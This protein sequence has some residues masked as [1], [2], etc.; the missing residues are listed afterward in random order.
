MGYNGSAGIGGRNDVTGELISGGGAGGAGGG[1]SGG[2][3]GGGGSGGSGGGGGGGGGG[4]PFFLGNGGE[5]GD[6]GAGGFGG[7]GGSGG[8]GGIGGIGGA[9]GGAMQIYAY[10]RITLTNAE[11]NAQGGAGSAGTSGTAGQAGTAGSAGSGGQPGSGGSLLG[12]TGGTGGSGAAGGTG[13]SGGA[14]G[15]GGTGGGGAGGTIKL[16]GSVV[17]GIGT[18]I[19]AEGGA[20]GNA[21]AL[22]RFVL[23]QNAGFFATQK[24][25]SVTFNPFTGL[26]FNYEPTINARGGAAEQVDGPMGA[27]PMIKPGVEAVATP[28]IPGLEGGAAPFGLLQLDSRT[29]LNQAVFDAATQKGAPL[30][31]VRVDGGIGGLVDDFAGYDL[32]LFANLTDSQTFDDPMLGVGAQAFQHALMLGGWM[33]DGQFVTDG[34][35]DPLAHL[36]PGEIYAMLVPEDTSFFTVTASLGSGQDKVSFLASTETL[37]DGQ[38]LFVRPPGGTATVN[39]QLAPAGEEIGG[40]TWQQLVLHQGGGTSGTVHVGSTS[41]ELEILLSD[42]SGGLVAADAVMLRKVGEVL[43]HLRTLTLDGNPL[44]NRAHDIFLPA[45]Q[46]NAVDV[47]FD[48]DLAPVVAPVANQPSTTA[49]SFDGNDMAVIYASPSLAMTGSSTVELRFQIASADRGWTN[50]IHKSDGSGYGSRAFSVWVNQ[51][52]GQMFLSTSDAIG[53]QYWYLPA[54]TVK[55]GEWYEFA[56]VID[57]TSGTVHAYLNGAEVLSATIRTNAQAYAGTSFYVGNRTGGQGFTGVIDDLAIWAEARSFAEV[58]EDFA[59]GVDDSQVA[60]HWRFDAGELATDSSE[61]HNGGYADGATPVLGP[62]RLKVT[63]APGDPIDL[64]PVFDDTQVNVT[65]DGVY[66]LVTPVSGFT[67]TAHVTLVARDG[68][69]APHDFR[70]RES[71]TGFDVTFGANAIYGNKFNDID[72]DGVRDAGEPGVEGIQ[73]FLDDNGNGALDG[74][75][76]VTWT[77]LNGDYAFRGLPLRRVAG[78]RAGGPRGLAG[79][80]AERRRRGHRLIANDCDRYRHAQRGDL[81]VQR[82]DTPGRAV[83]RRQ[84]PGIRRQQ[85]KLGTHRLIHDRSALQARQHQHLRAPCPEDRRHRFRQAHVRP[86]DRYVVRHVRAHDRGRPGRAAVLQR[87][88]VDPGRPVVSA[89]GGHRSRRGTG[90]RLSE[91]HADLVRQQRHSPARCGVRR[92]QPP[93][94]RPYPGIRVRRLCRRHRRRSDLERRAQRQRGRRGFLHGRRR[95]GH[96]ARGALGIQRGERWRRARRLR[97]QERRRA[98]RRHH[99]RVAGAHQCGEWHGRQPRRVDYAPAGSDEQQCDAG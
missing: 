81:H 4:Q 47:S 33:R 54:G 50:L 26:Q 15:A 46:S 93:A 94:H 57:R 49:A 86:V 87:R 16:V 90:E 3:G 99:G 75:E 9:G 10:G 84:R 6:G 79:R 60:G 27:N 13:G 89:C 32:L 28:Y 44:D 11:F 78:L 52:N 76:Q 2:G 43:P 1:G 91:R 23:G 74:G 14:G 73:I 19:H 63:D 37:S 95:H 18:E 30:A 35:L 41:P 92:K 17:N 34:G 56:S 24:L 71:E 59:A 96:R 22:G 38:V 31:L 77:D 69:G 8:T 85:R 20:G 97:Q 67:G 80:A 98:R 61:N 48:A 68:S 83:V 64:L 45:V 51:A 58:N 70:G 25:V 40:T 62:I 88:R 7:F 12:G 66:L 36:N 53:E 29:V 42:A 55:P 5:G 39:Q 82:R 21:G 72:A 65:L